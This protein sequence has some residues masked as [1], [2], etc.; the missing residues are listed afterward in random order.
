LFD[1][2]PVLAGGGLTVWA[3]LGLTGYWAAFIFVLT[4][5]ASYV[6]KQREF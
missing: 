2:E 3:L 1:A 6:F 5:L 4:S